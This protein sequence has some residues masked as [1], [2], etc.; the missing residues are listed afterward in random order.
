[1]A[2]TKEVCTY[3]PVVEVVVDSVVVVDGTSVVFADFIMNEYTPN[4]Q[5]KCTRQNIPAILC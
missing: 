4:K 5:T 1:V 3:R 2:M